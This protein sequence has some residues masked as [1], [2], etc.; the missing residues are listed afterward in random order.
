MLTSHLR[1]LTD[2]LNCR[3]EPFLVLE[4][5]TIEEF[6]TGALLE[7]AV[8]AQVNLSTVLF[9]FSLSTSRQAGCCW[10][11]RDAAPVGA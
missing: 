8:F 4:G 2:M 11:R 1:R 6:L 9:A 10:D 5:V 7:S 3:D